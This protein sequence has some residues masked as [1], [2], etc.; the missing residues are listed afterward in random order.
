VALAQR[1][2]YDGMLLGVYPSRRYMSAKVRTFLD[3]LSERRRFDMSPLDAPEAPATP[4]RS[5]R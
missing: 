4:A 5:A 1:F 3:C 2:V